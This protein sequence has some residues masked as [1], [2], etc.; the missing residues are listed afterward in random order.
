MDA[1]EKA[2]SWKIPRVYEYSKRMSPGISAI[3]KPAE[4]TLVLLFVIIVEIAVSAV[5]ANYHQHHHHY[6]QQN[7]YKTPD[8]S[9]VAGDDKS[10]V[11]K[12]IGNTTSDNYGEFNRSTMCIYIIRIY[13]HSFY[14]QRNTIR[15][16]YE[17]RTRNIGSIMH[18]CHK[19]T[20][21]QRYL[22]KTCVLSIFIDKHQFFFSFFFGK[23]QRESTWW[24]T[25]KSIKDAE[26][27]I[28][29]FFFLTK[30]VIRIG[31]YEKFRLKNILMIVLQWKFFSLNHNCE[32]YWKLQSNLINLHFSRQN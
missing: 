31:F 13:N 27:L 30:S 21:K 6:Q 24:L 14:P 15:M 3:W 10:D 11:E 19:N 22:D 2:Q 5:L 9:T 23:Q 8:T 28:L 12:S 4:L 26:K 25:L 20:L 32:F 17:S 29:S 1:N 16:Y 7:D 18:K